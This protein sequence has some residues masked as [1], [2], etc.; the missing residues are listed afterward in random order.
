LTT[1]NEIG[2]WWARLLFG[3][4]QAHVCPAQEMPT[5]LEVVAWWESK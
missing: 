2:L 4:I 1:Q 3:T 5:I